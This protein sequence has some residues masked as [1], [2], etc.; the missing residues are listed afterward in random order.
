MLLI[1]LLRTT[2]ARENVVL[3]SGFTDGLPGQTR[4]SAHGRGGLKS[5]P[6]VQ[7][8]DDQNPGHFG[9]TSQGIAP[10]RT[11]M[12]SRATLEKAVAA[13]IYFENPC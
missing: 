1:P 11:V 8:N 4:T 3:N 6:E 2:A 9:L 12:P 5:D 10:Q 7:E 13:R